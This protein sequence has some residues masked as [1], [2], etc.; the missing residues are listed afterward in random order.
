MKL[1][2]PELSPLGKVLLTIP[3]LGIFAAGVAWGPLVG[4]AVATLVV[5]GIRW[6]G[7]RIGSRLAKGDA[8]GR[9]SRSTWAVVKNL[10]GDSAIAI[11]SLGAFG[12]LFWG[13]RWASGLA[14]NQ[15]DPLWGVFVR[16]YGTAVFVIAAVFV[17]TL[18]GL[19]RLLELVAPRA[20]APDAN[21]SLKARQMFAGMAGM[22]TAAFSQFA[23]LGGAGSLA[24]L[25]PVESLRYALDVAANA[26]LQE[27]PDTFGLHLIEVE[28][29]DT[30]SRVATY[31]FRI[32][33]L[34]VAVGYGLTLKWALE[35]PAT[36]GAAQ[37]GGQRGAKLKQ[38]RRR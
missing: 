1:K 19:G 31:V 23:W 32:L 20:G 6:V 15:N 7:E 29:A 9:R 4:G 36:A 35:G 5:L 38:R 11:V 21:S 24:K 22:M 10:L 33:I 12:A 8:P 14:H 34:L 28:L 26:L 27:L 30:P 13:V 2:T 25:G 18:E 16:V 37:A 17:V 3:L